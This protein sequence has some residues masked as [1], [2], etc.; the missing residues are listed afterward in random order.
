LNVTSWASRPQHGARRC[1]ILA[2]W[3]TW[4]SRG[5][6]LSPKWD[7]LH[8]QLAIGKTSARDWPR[9]SHDGSTSAS[10]IIARLKCHGD[11]TRGYRV[12]SRRLRRGRESARAR[13]VS[14]AQDRAAN[15][16]TWEDQFG[17][18]LRR[19]CVVQR[20]RPF[21]LARTGWSN[22]EVERERWLCRSRSWER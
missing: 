3:S 14:R 5:F 2:R 18:A 16:H 8:R 4:R 20:K 10:I 17:P 6:P 15:R 7:G 9:T 19:D 22:S 12:R 1:A 21:P 13:A 11:A